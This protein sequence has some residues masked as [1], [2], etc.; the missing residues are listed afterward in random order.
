M[1]NIYI[2]AP[3]PMRDGAIRIMRLFERSGI[4]VTSRW[5]KAPDELCDEHARKDLEDVAAADVL[6]AW[7][8]EGWEEKG[9]GGRHVEFGYALALGIPIVLAGERS[10]IFHHLSHVAVVDD[11]QDIVKAV[12][13]AAEARTTVTHP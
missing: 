11:S 3:Y 8:P 5:L 6:F 9:T 10:N 7:N 2:A 1:I 12:R 13:Q 4:A